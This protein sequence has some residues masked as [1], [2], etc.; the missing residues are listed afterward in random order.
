MIDTIGR[1]LGYVGLPLGT[2]VISWPILFNRCDEPVVAKGWM[3]FLGGLALLVWDIAWRLIKR[4]ERP[5][6]K[7][8]IAPNKA[9]PT[10]FVVPLWAFGVIIM[11]GGWSMI[12]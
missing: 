7:S 11:M 3:I 2:M 1:W 9:V 10:F 6:P 8:L 12:S 4:G 5:I